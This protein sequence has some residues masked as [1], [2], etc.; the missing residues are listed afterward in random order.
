MGEEGLFYYFEHTGDADSPSLGSH[1]MVIA[2]HN[3]SFKPNKQAQIRFTQ[4]GAVMKEDGIDR[5]RTEVRQQ[6]NALELSSWDYRSIG[7]RPVS[8]VSA[9]DSDAQFVHRDTLAPYAYE[10]RQQGQRLADHQLEGLAAHKE[11][12]VCRAP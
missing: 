8:S 2:Y 9:D 3:G 6:T 11:V 10:S 5:W 7:Q 1:T 4:S 12:Q